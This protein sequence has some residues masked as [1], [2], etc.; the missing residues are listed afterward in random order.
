M[1]KTLSFKAHDGKILEF[2]STPLGKGGEGSVYKQFDKTGHGDVGD[3]AKIFNPLKRAGKEEKLKAMLKIK[4]PQPSY[5][6]VW[7]KSLLYDIDTGEFCGYVMYLKFNKVELTDVYGYDSQFRQEKDW[8]FFVNIAKNL[9]LAVQGVHDI[10]QVIGD[11]NDKNI[12]VSPDNCEITLIDNDSFHIVS[13]DETYRCAVGRS[14]CIPAEVQDMNFRTASLPTFTKNTDS[15]SLAILIFKLLMNGTHPFNS[16]GINEKSIEDNIINGKSPYFSD[17]KN[18]EGAAFYTPSVDMLPM[19]LKRLFYR[20]F[21]A[22]PDTRPSAKEFYDELSKLEKPENL[23][24]CKAVTWH[25][26]P[27]ISRETVEQTITCP[28]CVVSKRQ[29]E[30][31]RK[32]AALSIM[33]ANT[34]PDYSIPKMPTAPLPELV[35]SANSVAVESVATVASA[36]TPSVAESAISSPVPP[37]PPAK[38]VTS[39]KPVATAKS[40]SDVSAI[41]PVIPTTPE[42]LRNPAVTAKS[43]KAERAARIDVAGHTIKPDEPKS[44]E[45]ATEAVQSGKK[46]NESPVVNV[47]FSEAESA[48]K[49]LPF[50]PSKIKKILPVAGVFVAFSAFV[51]FA[52]LLDNNGG[53]DVPAFLD[54]GWCTT[55]M[56]DC[57]CVEFPQNE[58]GVNGDFSDNSESDISTSPS[59]TDDETPTLSEI[60]NETSETTDESDDQTTDENDGVATET[61]P[62][63]TTTATPREAT[64]TA[65]SRT[66]PAI[67]TTRGGGNITSPSVTTPPTTTRTTPPT[68]RA[69]PP[70]TTRATS[71]TTRATPPTTT[72]TTPRTT[73]RATT[74][75]RRPTVT[76]P[77]PV[78]PVVVYNM[79]TD[80]NLAQFGGR[81]SSEQSSHTL[82]RSWGARRTVNMGSPRNIIIE[83]R[84]GTSQGIGINLDAL[85]TT[86]GRTYRFELTGRVTSGSGSHNM[87]VETV[88]LPN[89][90]GNQLATTTAQTNATF[91]I[92]FDRTAAQIDADRTAGIGAYRFGGAGPQ[93]G[94]TSGQTLEITGITI[95]RLGS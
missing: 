68:T 43:V 2:E 45:T 30:Q 92:R 66:T 19:A 80:I 7:P 72:R 10:N 29:E 81:S 61:T 79:A 57:E 41:S 90:R 93:S 53:E 89:T 88:T 62:R 78:P 87:F 70:T 14:E 67:T 52:V 55:D 21:G 76:T 84:G 86:A 32:I 4:S 65:P 18:L 73:T 11:L 38:S 36:I 91:T 83:N 24:S 75:T 95:T 54:C 46:E 17:V 58:N 1:T 16:V 33:P 37:A 35:T 94:E 5:N 48:G 64:T 9:A 15:F 23:Q 31:L 44:T 25:I 77:A 22:N 47:K 60:D 39:T 85:T 34:T 8:R 71:P 56:E 51:L 50:L 74:T 42:Q 26:F 59:A 3:L 6:Y 82:L 63:V 27:D 20:A 49:S 69:T 28:W 13:E 40:T 12:L